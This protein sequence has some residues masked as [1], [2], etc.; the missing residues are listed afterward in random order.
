MDKVCTNGSAR[1]VA[2]QCLYF[3]VHDEL[4]TCRRCGEAQTLGGMSHP[5]ECDD[6]YRDETGVTAA[7]AAACEAADVAALGICD[8]MAAVRAGKA[9]DEDVNCLPEGLA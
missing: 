2:G 8:P 7:A 9:A 3:P 5:P 1:D 4:G 6:T